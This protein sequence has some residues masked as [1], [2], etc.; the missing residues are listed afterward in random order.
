MNIVSIGVELDVHI[1]DRLVVWLPNNW[2]DGGVW[3]KFSN[4]LDG[5]HGGAG[6]RATF[7]FFLSS[8]K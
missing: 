7:F 5:S 4:F 3:E 6:S 8:N 2:I 1:V